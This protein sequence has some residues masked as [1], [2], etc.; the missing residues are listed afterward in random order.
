[1][2]RRETEDDELRRAA[3]TCTVIVNALM[4]LTHLSNSALPRLSGSKTWRFLAVGL[5]TGTLPMNNSS[6]PLGGLKNSF[7]TDLCVTFC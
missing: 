1:M 4:N 6:I 7:V 5:R 2:F 3:G